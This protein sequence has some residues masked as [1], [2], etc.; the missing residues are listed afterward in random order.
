M[1]PRALLKESVSKLEGELKAARMELELKDATNKL[2]VVQLEGELKEANT[3]LELQEGRERREME[4]VILGPKLSWR[5]HTVGPEA[6]IM[7]VAG[8]VPCCLLASS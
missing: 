4:K 1:L 2:K 7:S 6:E 3:K 5:R 8:G